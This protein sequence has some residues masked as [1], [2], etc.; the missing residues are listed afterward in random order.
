MPTQFVYGRHTVT[1]Y[2]TG[3]HV[4]RVLCASQ[5]ILHEIEPLCKHQSVRVEHVSNQALSKLVPGA[6]HQGVLA[7]VEAY[8]MLNE[9]ALE[10]LLDTADGHMRWLVLDQVQDPHNLGACIRTAA[11][12]GVGAII[13]P[14][15]RAVGL[16]ST[17]AKVASGALGLVPVIQVTNL[18]RQLKW[19]KN[20]GFWLYGADE[21]GDSS[22]YDLD[23]KGKVAWVM[24]SEGKGLRSLTQ[25]HCDVLCQIPSSD[26]L[27]CLNVSVATGVCLF[28]TLR[29]Q[30]L[31]KG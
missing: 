19:L 17:V 3:G 11:V 18:V 15:D 6:N 28:E 5:E 22:L 20:H 27:S 14:K 12:A 31:I 21:R 2:L 7:E 24:G 4:E 1:S 23:L 29:Q 16:T 25:S 8:H 30:T 26:Q 13:V 9:S 10:P